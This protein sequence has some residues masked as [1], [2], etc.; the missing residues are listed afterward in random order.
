[1]KE[2]PQRWIVA[3][4]DEYVHVVPDWDIRPHANVLT[5]IMGKF[6]LSEENCD[7]KPKIELEDDEGRAIKPMIIHNSFLHQ[8]KVKEA[9]TNLTQDK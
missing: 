5:P 7:C 6:E 3:E 1:M 8:K 9:I 2:E 4:E